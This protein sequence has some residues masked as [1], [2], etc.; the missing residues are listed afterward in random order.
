M[1]HQEPAYK[2][3]QYSDNE[4]QAAIFTL[5]SQDSARQRSKVRSHGEK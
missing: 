5:T 4:E 3:E 2:A 1:L